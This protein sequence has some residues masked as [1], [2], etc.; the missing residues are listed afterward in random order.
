MEFATR[1]KV[2]LKLPYKVLRKFRI[3][4]THKGLVLKYDGSFLSGEASWQSGIPYEAAKKIG[5]VPHLPCEYPQ[6]LP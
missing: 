2:M 3:G 4:V 6:T 5:G 1:D